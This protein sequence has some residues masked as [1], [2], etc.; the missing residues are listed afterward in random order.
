MEIF[1]QFVR[2]FGWKNKQDESLRKY[3]IGPYEVRVWRRTKSP[4][5]SWD[6]QRE[7]IKHVIRR[8]ADAPSISA[9]DIAYVISTL[10][11]IACVAITDQAGNGLS[12]YPDWF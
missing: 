2:L 3:Q 12:H 9:P 6:D 8:C 11:D 1:R 7:D 10:P 5:E 4:Q